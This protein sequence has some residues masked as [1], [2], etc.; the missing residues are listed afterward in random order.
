MQNHKYFVTIE[1]GIISGGFGSSILEYFTEY[2]IN[3][4]IKII[5]IRDEFKTHGS[6]KELLKISG[7]DVDNIEKTIM[8]LMNET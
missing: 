2:N 4:M 5:G 6:R 8:E 7:L 3:K 1:E